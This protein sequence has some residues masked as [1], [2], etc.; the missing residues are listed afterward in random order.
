MVA[1]ARRFGTWV[2]V[3]GGLVPASRV[4]AG[5]EPVPT[6]L[7]VKSVAR[8]LEILAT[9]EDAD[10]DRAA[11]AL[12]KAGK[13]VVAALVRM[14]DTGGARAGAWA[15]ET[16][17]RLGSDGAPAVEALERGLLREGT[18]WP[19]AHALE[20]IG[21][22]GV[23]ALVRG[24]A[25]QREESRRASLSSLSKASPLPAELFAPV[26]KR[27]D[28]S[29][30]GMRADAIFVIAAS[31]APASTRRS[32]LA[33]HVA[34]P[35]DSVRAAIAR[36][37]VAASGGEPGAVLPLAL[38]CGDPAEHVRAAATAQIVLA[39]RREDERDVVSTTLARALAD[40]AD[41]VRRAAMVAVVESGGEFV[42]LQERVL[43]EPRT[44]VVP[45]LRAEVVRAWGRS[46]RG[47]DEVRARLEPALKDESAF[48]RIAAA[49][50]LARRGLE[51]ERAFDV[52][53]GEAGIYHGDARVRDAVVRACGEL[54][55]WARVAARARLAPILKDRAEEIRRS[56]EEAMERLKSSS[57]E[58]R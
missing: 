9:G 1:R 25:A 47:D 46:S 27:L 16:L 19:C 30:E 37:I 26:A 34:D 11:N 13:S 28:D 24:L 43:V 12:A 14:L 54:G 36:S 45:E 55:T 48:V 38:L 51:T 10:R 2:L 50:G 18:D 20:R 39:V 8:W 32:A 52:L 42:T 5:D 21:P 22:A 41:E 58:K 6:S 35:S 29:D 3:F 4:D 33:A 57:A 40:P 49:A 44:E 56:A 17:A 31:L 53:F 23:P 15:A 7:D